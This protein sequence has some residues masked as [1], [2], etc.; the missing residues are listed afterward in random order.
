MLSQIHFR[1]T[2]G[3]QIPESLISLSRV[4]STITSSPNKCPQHLYMKMLSK[5]DNFTA[6]RQFNDPIE[7]GTSH[8]CWTIDTC[9]MTSGFIK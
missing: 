2:C 5:S 6:R 1:N 9:D 7:I 3:N 4:L 8:S